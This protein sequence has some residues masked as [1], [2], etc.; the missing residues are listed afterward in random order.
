M[1]RAGVRVEHV[2]VSHITGPSVADRW[3]QKETQSP[4][5]SELVRSTSRLSWLFSAGLV[6]FYSL[7]LVVNQEVNM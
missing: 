4:V 2:T 7:C 1:S 3:R 6:V 5:C